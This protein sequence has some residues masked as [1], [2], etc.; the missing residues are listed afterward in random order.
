MALYRFYFN[1][2]NEK[3]QV[4]SI[5]QGEGP[6]GNPIGEI[7]VQGIRLDACNADSHYNPDA[8]NVL[9][10]KAWFTVDGQLKIENGIAVIG[11]YD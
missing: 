9:A 7:N 5:D 4:W 2:H 11:Y 10:P 3:P 8:D 6:D 1:R